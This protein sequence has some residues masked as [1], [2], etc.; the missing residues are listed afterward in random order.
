[1]LKLRSRYLRLCASLQVD[2]GSA[3]QSWRFLEARYSEPHRVY[4]TLEHIGQ[5][6]EAYDSLDDEDPLLELAIWYHDCIY[7]SK[8]DDN[9]EQSALSF[10][11][12]LGFRLPRD[13]A[14]KVCSLILATNPRR[15][16]GH[17][18]QENLICDIDLSAF[19]NTEATEQNLDRIR[20]EYSY[21]PRESFD[22]ARADLLEALIER[23]IFHTPYFKPFEKRA[24]QNIQEQIRQLRRS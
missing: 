22:S 21:V 9:E 1:M 17:D 19:I 16:R 24:V 13:S 7:N 20:F 10:R 12:L 8:C 23:G 15:P 6:L 3:T 2:R 11:K 5:M 18:L 4:H 14:Q